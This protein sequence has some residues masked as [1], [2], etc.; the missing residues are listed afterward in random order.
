MVQI[1]LFGLENS[2]RDSPKSLLLH[3]KL[4]REYQYDRKL[5]GAFEAVKKEFWFECFVTDTT[6]KSVWDQFPPAHFLRLIF[7]ALPG[8]GGN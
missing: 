4:T 2:R 3:H 8:L 5:S 6:V 1:Q 7:G